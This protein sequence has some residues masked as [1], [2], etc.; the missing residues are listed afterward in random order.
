MGTS[1][2]KNLNIGVLEGFISHIRPIRLK[3][4]I[5]LGRNIKLGKYLEVWYRK[6]RS[7]SVVMEVG[8]VGIINE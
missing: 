4:I 3:G 5:M 7:S 2:Y 8:R 6:K 1:E